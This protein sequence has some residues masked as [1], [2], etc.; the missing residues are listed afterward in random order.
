MLKIFGLS[1]PVMSIILCAIIL[2]GGGKALV[3][4]ADFKSVGGDLIAAGGSIPSPSANFFSGY[5][6]W[7]KGVR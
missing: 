5:I 1:Y 7:A 6:S 2:A 4:L 3:G